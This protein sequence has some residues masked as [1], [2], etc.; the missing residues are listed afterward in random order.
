MANFKNYGDVNFYDNGVL[1]Q[2]VS[3]TEFK[4][5]TCGVDEDK[6]NSYLLT[7]ATVDL[8]DID[9][10]DMRDICAWAGMPM[11]T[12]LS[13][14]QNNDDLKAMLA[15]SVV[16]YSYTL[17][18]YEQDFKSKNEIIDFINHGYIDELDWEFYEKN[19]YESNRNVVVEVHN[20]Y[21]NTIQ[22]YDTLE[23]A[24]ED[25]E[26]RAEKGWSLTVIDK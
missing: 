13:E 10:D 22:V 20:G 26:R 8:E 7:V 6:E 18:S 19:F 17:C 2:Q 25:F 16:G 4:V 9:T 5:I 3:E 14:Y 1:V 21:N 12:S 24:L 15:S 23:D 11:Y